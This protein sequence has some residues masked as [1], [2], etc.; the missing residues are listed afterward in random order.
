MDDRRTPEQIAEGRDAD[1][2]LDSRGYVVTCPHAR[3]FAQWWGTPDNL[4]I[5]LAECKKDHDDC[6]L[7]VKG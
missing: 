2:N 5:R 4:P 6:P 1:G 3:C 7:V